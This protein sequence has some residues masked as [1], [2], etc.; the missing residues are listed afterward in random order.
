MRDADS[1]R[2]KKMRAL[3]VGCLDFLFSVLCFRRIRCRKRNDNSKEKRET[4]A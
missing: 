4:Q 1:R 3:H 2:G